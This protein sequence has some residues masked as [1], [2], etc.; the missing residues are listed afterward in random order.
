M[1]ND[2]LKDRILIHHSAFCIQHFLLAAL[3]TF[4]CLPTGT[5]RQ[6]RRQAIQVEIMEW[7]LS[8]L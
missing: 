2:E 6:C 7:L 8:R 1:M 5:A 3:G 4:G